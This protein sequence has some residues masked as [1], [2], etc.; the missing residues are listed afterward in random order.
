[1]TTGNSMAK[2]ENPHI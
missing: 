1:M 2:F